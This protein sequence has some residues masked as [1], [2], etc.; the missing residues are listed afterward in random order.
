MPVPGPHRRSELGDPQRRPGPGVGVQEAGRFTRALEAGRQAEARELAERGGAQ[1][2]EV[3]TGGDPRLAVED[4][5]REALV[6]QGQG[7]GESRELR[8]EDEQRH[9]IH[10]SP[11]SPHRRRQPRQ[12]DFDG[13]I[14]PRTIEPGGV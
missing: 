7:G 11:R 13:A 1:G 3:V 6:R 9:R 4:V 14:G 12:I 5:H 2:D 8:A 10:G